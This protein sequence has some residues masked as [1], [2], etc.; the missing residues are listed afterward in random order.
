MA[1]NPP[2][3][4]QT[5]RLVL[6]LPSAEHLAVYTA[7]CASERSRFVGGPFDAAKAFEKL[8]AMAGHW[9]LRGYGRYVMTRRDG[10]APIGHV[11]ALHL[12]TESLPEM[13][14]TLWDPAAEGLGYAYEAAAA[15][16]RHAFGRLG[17][18]RMILRIDPDNARSCRLAERIGSP[19]RSGGRPPRNGCREP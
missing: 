1:G 7:Y 19:A 9:T 13:T 2:L 10:G 17:F 4:L 14:W 18:A 11:G 8:A 15:Y 3:I 16:A 12:E 5:E 6:A